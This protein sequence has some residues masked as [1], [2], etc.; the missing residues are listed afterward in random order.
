MRKLLMPSAS[1]HSDQHLCCSL[2]G[3]YNI[4]S[5]YIRNFKP[6]AS[7]CGCAGWLVS[8]LNENPEERFSRDEAQI[9]I[10]YGPRQANLVLIAYASSE[11]SVL[12]E[13]TLLAHTSSESGG[14]FRQKA[15]SLAPLNGW[16]CAVKICHGGMLKDTNSL[17]A[18]QITV[19]ILNIQIKSC[20]VSAPPIFRMRLQT[21]VLSP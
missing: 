2:S 4:S 16:T 7:F 19:M 15:R 6:L 21:E 20:W 3:W 14:T 5:F 8:Y 11:G 13:P 1:A 10:V 18:P 12:P 17:D 9:T